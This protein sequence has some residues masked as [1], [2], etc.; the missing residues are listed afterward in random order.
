MRSIIPSRIYN[1][2]FVSGLFIMLCAPAFTQTTKAQSDV[3]VWTPPTN[4]SRSGAAINPVMVVDAGGIIHVIWQDLVDGIIYTKGDGEQWDAPVQINPP[5]EIAELEESSDSKGSLQKATESTS[6][7]FIPVLIADTQ[8]SIHAFWTNEENKLLYSAAAGSNL[9]TSGW[10]APITLAESALTFDVTI[11]SN[12]RFHLSYLR[13]LN[14]SDFPAGIYYRSSGAAGDGWSSAALLYSSPYFRTADQDQANVHIAINETEAAQLVHVVWDNRPRDKIFIARSKDGG[15]SWTKPEVIREPGE[16]TQPSRS[17]GVNVAASSNGI[18]LVWQEGEPGVNCIQYY[19]YSTDQ[20]ETWQPYQRMQDEL[21]GCPEDYQLQV[22][23]EKDL[24]LLQAKLVN[25]LY[26]RVWNG[27]QWSNPQEQRELANSFDPE[28]FNPIDFQCIFTRLIREEK[29]IAVG[30]DAASGEDIWFTSRDLGTLKDWFSPPSE[31]RSP[32]TVANGSTDNTSLDLAADSEGRIHAIWT[33]TDGNAANGDPQTSIY[34]SLWD[35]NYWTQPSVILEPPFGKV[36]DLA[37]FVDGRGRLFVVWNGGKSGEVYLSWANA[38]LARSNSE[39][40]EPQQLPSPNPHTSSPNVIIEPTGT[41]SIAYSI[42]LNEDRGIYLIQSAD[43]GETWSDPIQIFNGVAAQWEM[44]D[45]PQLTYTAD[46]NLHILWRRYSLPPDEV[47]EGL[48]YARSE[49]DGKTWSDPQEVVGTPIIWSQIRGAGEEVVHRVWQETK[50]DLSIVWFEI[51]LDNGLTWSRPTNIATFSQ[52]QSSASLEADSQEQLHLLQFSEEVG[53]DL[54][55][56]EWTWDREAWRQ[57]ERINLGPGKIDNNSAMASVLTPQGFLGVLL[58]KTSSE[59]Q[60]LLDGELIFTGRSLDLLPVSPIPQTTPAP[61][62]EPT[63]TIQVVQDSEP[64]LIVT[65]ELVAR[66]D[67]D[68]DRQAESSK[69]PASSLIGG[70]ATVSLVM[71]VL[72]S[73]GVRSRKK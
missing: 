72:I 32:A 52:G 22:L 21:L 4:L 45:D 12:D 62:P 59:N 35:G 16:A 67:I 61:I 63:A 73:V 50:N 39:W 25:H 41:I 71:I 23:Q 8:G 36:V 55:L 44:I 60:N 47:S 13:A 26:L 70:V 42:R 9:A 40:V 5:F 57:G 54:N 10:S 68:S 3:E 1:F 53:G 33:K 49:D 19:Q 31:W 28:T 18:L 69:I 66:N 56:L 15:K 2:I 30:C 51:S 43:G 37:T 64:E 14:T 6:I 65:Q 46:G 11:D 24:I 27:S 34:Y 29:L 38:G 58:P 20:G 48:Y 7:G 17:F